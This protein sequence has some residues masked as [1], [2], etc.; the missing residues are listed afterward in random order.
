M[1]VRRVGDFA[2]CSYVWLR[3]AASGLPLSAE[4]VPVQVLGLL[5]CI[6]CH[7]VYLELVRRHQS[8]QAV[9]LGEAVR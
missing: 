1:A 2:C 8:H 6:N 9:R 7:L 5:L 4:Y 3:V